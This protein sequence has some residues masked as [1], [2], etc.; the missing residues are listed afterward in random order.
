MFHALP[1]LSEGRWVEEKKGVF[2]L[3]FPSTRDQQTFS[4]KDQIVNVLGTSGHMVSDTT[5]QLCHPSMTQT[6]RK[7]MGMGAFHENFID[8]Q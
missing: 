4:I 5:T 3:I 7:R 2:V 8:G 1:Y 6:T